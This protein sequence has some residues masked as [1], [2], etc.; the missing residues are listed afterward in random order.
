MKTIVETN[1]GKVLFTALEDYELQENQTLVDLLITENF[2]NPYYNFQT[3]LFYEQA[4]Q[5][6]VNDVK[7]AKALEI[8]LYYTDLITDVLGKH[9]NKLL[10]DLIPIPQAVLDE[11]DRL[12]AECNQKILDLGIDNF[13][14]RQQNIKL[15]KEL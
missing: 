15:Y 2:I 3:S 9:I 1:T 4:T 6:E 13:S 14:Y 11:R 8:D 10:I 5:D 12:K 7:I